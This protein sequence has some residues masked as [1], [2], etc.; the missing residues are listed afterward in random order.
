ML[1]SD[2]FLAKSEGP[3]ACN[4]SSV[5]EAKKRRA[6]LPKDVIVCDWH[7]VPVK[8]SAYASL[9]TWR[10]EGFETIGASWYM[11]NDIR[12]LAKGSIEYG[13]KGHLQC[14]WAG[15]NF[16]VD[17]TGY[18]WHQLWNFIY[19]AHYAWS[20]DDHPIRQLPFSVPQTFV[21]IWFDRQPVL[22]NRP[23]F[24]VDLTNLYNR[25]LNDTPQKTG[26]LGYGPDVDLSAFINNRDW[27]GETQFQVTPNKN[28][29]SALLFA[30][31]FNP[32]G[33][34]PKSLEIGL[35]GKTTSELHFLMN[36]AFP[37]LR[38]KQV[39]EIQFRYQDGT[40]E[41]MTLIYKRNL[42]AVDE[43][44]GSPVARIAWKGSTRNGHPIVLRDVIWTNPHKDKPL[45]AV[46]I[47]SFGTEASPVLFAI[48]GVN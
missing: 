12:N 38:N 5:E 8:P 41:A 29:Q 17:S 48:T 26:W 7:Y 18:D 25:T 45:D 43:V 34:Y 15:Y 24:Q 42:W 3:D 27:L 21:D 30:G 19:A 2:V 46:V 35:K 4:A 10:D 31:K 9:T 6:L 32:A 47:N 36:S 33:A 13:V 39:G 1:W 37:T 22:Q 20:G 28:K 16:Q 11:P 44:G 23:G 40:K 14:T